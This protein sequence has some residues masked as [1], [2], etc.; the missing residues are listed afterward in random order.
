M[1]FAVILGQLGAMIGQVISYFHS[2][3]I[4]DIL[5]CANVLVWGLHLV[6]RRQLPRA[7]VPVEN[8]DWD[9]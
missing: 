4:A 5:L 7:G 9:S 8:R 1:G 3:Q 2:N 6:I